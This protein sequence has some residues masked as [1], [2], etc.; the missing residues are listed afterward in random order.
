[1][2]RR[3][4]ESL[5]A[6]DAEATEEAITEEIIEGMPARLSWYPKTLLD[7]WHEFLFDL[8]GCELAKEFSLV[9]RE[10]IKQYQYKISTQLLNKIILFIMNFF[11]V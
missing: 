6:C 3:G 11:I 4:L 5:Q 9:E 7:L 1:M 8:S 2:H 10:K